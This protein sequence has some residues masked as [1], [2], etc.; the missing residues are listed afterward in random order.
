MAP[1]TITCL[2]LTAVGFTR[3]PDVWLYCA[4]RRRHEYF[5]RWFH[6][7]WN[8]SFIRGYSTPD[9]ECITEEELLLLLGTRV[10][11][12]HTM[13]AESSGFSL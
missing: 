5:E 3:M 9:G 12:E 6:S 7:E 1:Q 13:Q 11:N 2:Q 10:E 4:R 8:V